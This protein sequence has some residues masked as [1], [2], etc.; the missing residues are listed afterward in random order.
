MIWSMAC[1]SYTLFA[2]EDG[3]FYRDPS[4]QFPDS[5]PEIWRRNRQWLED[6]G[7]IRISVG[8]FLLTDGSRAVMV[9]AGA[10]ADPSFLGEGAASGRLPQALAMVGVRPDDVGVVI[11]TH[12]H[13][14]HVGGDRSPTGEPFFA[15]AR[16]LVQTAELEHWTKAEGEVAGRIRDILDGLGNEERVDAVDGEVEA[17]PGITLVPTPG[18]TPGHQSVVVMSRGS[19]TF[20]SGDVTHHPVQ[21]SFPQWGIPFDL[22]PLQANRT[23]ERVFQELAGTGSLLAAGHYPRPGMGYVETVD[24]VRVFVTGTPLHVG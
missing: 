2:I 3:W 10:G 9:D 5:D 20:I 23:R 12:L 24:D 14:D 13:L 7:R 22:D 17:A 21:A 18:H 1:G 16:H 15:N 6:D 11:H 4:I 19:R 8:C